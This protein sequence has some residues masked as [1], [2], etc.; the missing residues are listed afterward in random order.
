MPAVARSRQFRHPARLVVAGFAAVI[1]IG[2]ALLLLPVAT[3]APGGA[4][5]HDAVLQS[6]A[7]VTPA[8]LGIVDVPTCWSP[9]GRRSA[10]A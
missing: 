7:A 5:F 3:T 1:V 4:S 2:T 6:T 8:G 10:S 9:T